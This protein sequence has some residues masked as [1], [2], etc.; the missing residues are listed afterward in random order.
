MRYVHAEHEGS[1]CFRTNDAHLMFKMTGHNINDAY[2]TSL[3]AGHYCTYCMWQGYA[4]QG[5][6][7]CRDMAL[8]SH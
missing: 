6:N 8:S 4:M 2:Y 3:Q 7:P 5:I 1:I